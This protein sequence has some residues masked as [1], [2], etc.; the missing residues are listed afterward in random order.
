M[1]PVKKKL[2]VWRRRRMSL[3]CGAELVF[4]A[5]AMT[6]GAVASTP[7]TFP[8]TVNEELASCTSGC[9]ATS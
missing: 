2:G 4:V 9:A 7:V 5:A 8:M 1:A 6:M 3:A